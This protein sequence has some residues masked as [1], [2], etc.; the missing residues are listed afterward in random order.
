M[1]WEADRNRQEEKKGKEIGQGDWKMENNEI[2]FDYPGTGNQPGPLSWED[3]FN[4]KPFLG[5]RVP[6][7]SPSI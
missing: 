5:L 4:L 2:R 6:S 1:G 3:P 7:L